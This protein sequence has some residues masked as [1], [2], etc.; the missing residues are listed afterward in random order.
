MDSLKYAKDP[1]VARAVQHHQL[2]TQYGSALTPE[3]IDAQPY[4][5]IQLLRLCMSTETKQAKQ[6][7]KKQDFYAKAGVTPASMA[8]RL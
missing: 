3:I 1:E 6:S 2:F 4:R 7:S 5:Y 8:S